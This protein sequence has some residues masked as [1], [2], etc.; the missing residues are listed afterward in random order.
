MPVRS[1]AGAASGSSTPAETWE[2]RNKWV[3]VAW[4]PHA[5]LSQTSHVCISVRSVLSC[6]DELKHFKPE[7]W[8]VRVSLHGI[9][10]LPLVP[11]HSLTPASPLNSVRNRLKEDA[12]LAVGEESDWPPLVS[13][14]T[15]FCHFDSV[16]HVPFRWRDLPR[17]AVLNFEVLGLSWEVVSLEP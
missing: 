9:A 4:M 7:E 16:I 10:G 3:T 5:S 2:S 13:D 11:V 1:A 17:D 12:D 8:Q 6:L 14:V 15:H